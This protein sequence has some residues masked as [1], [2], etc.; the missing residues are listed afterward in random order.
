MSGRGCSASGWKNQSR[1][2][3]GGTNL[4]Q[5]AQETGMR[6]GEIERAGAPAA[7]AGSD[8]S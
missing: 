2:E 1:I 8:A 4:A 3:R 7:A 5:L 6:S